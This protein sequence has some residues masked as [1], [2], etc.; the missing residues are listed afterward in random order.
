MASSL[1]IEIVPCLQDNYAY[2]LHDTSTGLTGIVDPSEAGPVEKALKAKGVKLDFILNTHHHWD[3]TGA[4]EELKRKFSAKVVGP[5][6]DKDRIPGIDIPLANESWNFGSHALQALETPGHT[7]GHVCY[8]FEEDK[9]VFTGDTLFSIGCGRVFEGTMEQMW[10]SLSRLSSLPD[11]TRV[12]CGH[13]YT[14]ANARFAVT[15][16]PNNEAL[17]LRK[18][19][20]EQL[21]QQGQP[22]IP[23]TIAEERSFNPFLR[24]FSEEIRKN[25]RLGSSACDVDVFAALRL[26][27]DAF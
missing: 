12:F 24:P 1:E 25:L 9:A 13:E 6:T 18:K 7:T 11:D 23:T 26:A 16:K 14:V 17:Q 22:T 19:V 20:A 10:S 15:V 21:R 2:L 3:H 8:Y 27:K 5:K 4:N